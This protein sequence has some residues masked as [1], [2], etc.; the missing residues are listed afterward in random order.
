MLISRENANV[1]GKVEI[2]G[3]T[4]H[5]ANLIA[6]FPSLQLLRPVPLVPCEA[7]LKSCTQKDSKSLRWHLMPMNFDLKA[8]VH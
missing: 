7:E 2:G 4:S 1:G 5:H 6:C 8:A 3:A